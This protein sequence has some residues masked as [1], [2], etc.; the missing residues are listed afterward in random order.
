MNLSMNDGA[1]LVTL[2]ER[3]LRDLS[4]QLVDALVGDGPTHTPQLWRM[5]PE[6]YLGVIIEP[7]KEHYGD[8]EPGPGSGLA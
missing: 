7:D 2:S 8:R 6:G 3:N 5:T 1:V 4:A